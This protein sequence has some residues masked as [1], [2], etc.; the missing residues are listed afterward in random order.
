[1]ANC[2]APHTGPATGL[3]GIGLHSFEMVLSKSFHRPIMLPPVVLRNTSYNKERPSGPATL[4]DMCIRKLNRSIDS[5]NVL[6]LMK[7]EP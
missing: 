5:Y 6:E 7:V 4:Q 1:M 3:T 2:V